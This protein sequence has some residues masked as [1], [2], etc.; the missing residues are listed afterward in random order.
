M[1]DFSL[2]LKNKDENVH[3]FPLRA[4]RGELFERDREEK[5]R[6]RERKRER[7]PHNLEGE[8]WTIQ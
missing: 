4:I 8:A 3:R 7:D 5:K 2:L 6:E 1:I